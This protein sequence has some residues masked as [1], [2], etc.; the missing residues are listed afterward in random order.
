MPGSVLALHLKS[1]G[2]I[3]SS[4]SQL[5]T[6]RR[7]VTPAGRR[8]F[9]DSSTSRFTSRLPPPTSFV[10]RTRSCE[11]T[12][13]RFREFKNGKEFLEKDARGRKERER[14]N[15][16][17]K[18]GGEKERVGWRDTVLRD[19]VGRETRGGCELLVFYC[20]LV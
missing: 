7:S 4:T 11:W 5:N 12:S 20:S 9:L 2:V 10:P 14:E 17:R 1:I 19:D 13:T 16:R 6:P 8:T 3:V 18:M 15:E